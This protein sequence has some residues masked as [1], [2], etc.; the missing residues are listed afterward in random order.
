MRRLRRSAAPGASWRPWVHFVRSTLITLGLSGALLGS[1]SLG[2]SWALLVSTGFVLAL[3]GFPGSSGLL[4]SPV[5]F[6]G[7]LGSPG[8]VWTLLGSLGLVLA[9]LGSPGLSWAL[10]VSPGLV[11]ALL[12]RP[13]SPGLSWV[14]LGFVGQRGSNFRG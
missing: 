12:A 3:L 9:L 5:L 2:L 4:G 13:G 1:L 11:W 7:R 6:W 14:H 8:V 10:L